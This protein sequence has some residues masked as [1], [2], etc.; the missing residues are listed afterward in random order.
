MQKI[1][2]RMAHY[3]PIYHK[4]FGGA[5]DAFFQQECPQLGGSRTRQVLVHS[6]TQ[7]VDAYFPTPTR[8]RQ[9][10]IM[11]AAV[12]K[13]EAPGYGKKMLDLRQVPVVLD[14][15]QEGD[16]LA[17]G[18]GKSFQA[19]REE[20]IARLYQQAFEQGGCLATADLAMILKLCP[21][22]IGIATREWEKVHDTFLPRRGV[23]HD[24]GRTLTHKRIIVRKLFLEGKKVEDVCRETCHSPEAVH[25]YIMNFKQVLLCYRK[26]L[27]IEQT[28][29][30]IHMSPSLVREYHAL[31]KDLAT[32]NHALDAI[33]REE[34]LP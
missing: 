22:T 1:D 23:I 32:H 9:G 17:I 7:M 10:Q 34:P 33:L 13:D 3:G 28:A 4:G 30:A 11:W 14:L 8:M 12:A 18:H 21:T 24:V 5:L 6:I 27:D 31:I 20:T 2:Q 15:V 16:A 29:F 26:G 19:L 25:R